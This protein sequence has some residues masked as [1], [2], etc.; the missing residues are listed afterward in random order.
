SALAAVP[1]PALSALGHTEGPPCV[2]LHLTPPPSPQRR[3][4]NAPACRPHR[5]NGGAPRP[6]CLRS[7]PGAPPLCRLRSVRCAVVSVLRRGLGHQPWSRDSAD[8]RG[9][10]ETASRIRQPHPTSPGASYSLRQRSSAS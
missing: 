7:G 8:S 10:S 9:R 6:L 5:H 3:H 4:L 2:P 1:S